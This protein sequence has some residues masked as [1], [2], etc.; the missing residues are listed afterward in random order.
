MHGAEGFGNANDGVGGDAEDAGGMEWFKGPVQRPA[1]QRLLA[2][3][4]M[5]KTVTERKILIRSDLIRCHT[6]A[7]H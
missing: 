7:H 2:P 6:I 4:M 3:E 1:S 5:I